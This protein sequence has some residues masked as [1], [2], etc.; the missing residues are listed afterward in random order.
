MFESLSL[1]QADAQEFQL[2]LKDL[3]LAYMLP[4]REKRN[5]RCRPHLKTTNKTYRI[6]ENYIKFKGKDRYLYGAVDSTGRRLIAC[7]RRNEMCLR[8]TLR[9]FCHKLIRGSSS[10][11]VFS[12]Y[13]FA[14][15]WN[16]N[17]SSRFPGRIAVSCHHFE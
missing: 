4:F 9:R 11:S 16:P 12:P 14:I 8:V 7:S 1:G 13:D 5:K 10:A 17:G 2:T 3:F 15:V 6:D